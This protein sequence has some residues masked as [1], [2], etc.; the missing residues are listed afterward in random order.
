MRET[1]GTIGATLAI[2]M[3][4]VTWAALMRVSIQDAPEFGSDMSAQQARTSTVP[5]SDAFDYDRYGNRGLLTQRGTGRLLGPHRAIRGV[6][7]EAVLAGDTG[8]QSEFFVQRT[9]P[10]GRIP[11]IPVEVPERNPA[12][13]LVEFAESA[14]EQRNVSIAS[15]PADGAD[16]AL[17]FWEYW[18]AD[19]RAGEEVQEEFPAGDVSPRPGSG[20]LPRRARC[21]AWPAGCRPVVRAVRSRTPRA[22]FEPA[23]YSLGG[24][25]SIRL[26]YRGSG[27]DDS[28]CAS[29]RAGG[30]VACGTAWPRA[31]RHPNRTAAWRS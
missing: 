24:S 30:E 19:D 27:G 20:R 2:V 23:A 21:S 26:S 28:P 5:V 6:S 4:V 17:A 13:R 25:R 7:E 15:S 31:A 9:T 14:D 11:S 29:T 3:L 22:G 16:P 10:P 18:D 8:E 12:T 1:I